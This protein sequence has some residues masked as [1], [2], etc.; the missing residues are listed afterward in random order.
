MATATHPGERRELRVV[1]AGGGT[2]GHLYP[3]LAIADEIRKLRRDAAIVFIGTR[4]RIEERVVPASGYTLETIWISGFRRTLS[5]GTL[6]FPI[7]LVV[8]LV[9]SLLLLRRIQP[10]VVVGTGGYVCGPVLYCATL[11]GI[12]TLIQEQNSY[13]G[14]TTRLLAPRV[15]EVHITF[16]STR[17]Y[18]RRRDGIVLSGNPTRSSLGTVSRGEALR[19][20]GLTSA[21]KTLLVFG[22]SQGSVAVN[23][24]FLHALSGVLADGA[25]VIW[26]TG[27]RDIERITSS[28]GVAEA[29]SKGTLWMGAYIDQMA[30]AYAASDLVLCRAGATTLAE[31]T[32][33]GIGSV[34]V[35]LP[36]AAADHQTGNAQA[37][38][39]AGAAVMVR[40]AEMNDR[41]FPVLHQLLSDAETL[42]AMAQKAARMGMPD[43]AARLARAVLARAGT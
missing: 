37:M 26:Q 8:S 28:P 20:F 27:E 5:V 4:G 13:P 38:V 10:Q 2:G 14:I 39:D 21:Q 34:L 3:A 25:Q 23:S 36:T 40:E 9:Q 24:G 22:G 6:I 1:F 30:M 35:P 19:F 32:R 41:L 43:A 12:P 7:K 42:T 16:E 15:D 31:L 33:V 17:K 29:I 18:L 11:L